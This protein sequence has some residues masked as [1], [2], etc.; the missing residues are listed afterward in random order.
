MIDPNHLSAK[1][2]RVMRLYHATGYCDA[3]RPAQW[4]ALRFFATAPE[5][6]RTVSGLARA[7]ASTMGTTS[8]TVSALV[9]RGLLA[10]AVDHRNVGLTVTQAGLKLLEDADPARTLES[11]LAQLPAGERNLLDRALSDI[12]RALE[13]G[14]DRHALTGPTA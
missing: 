1:L 9:D 4:Q 14:G 8:V 7:R 2:E 6:E 12:I 10:R 13:P 5:A 3:L 11:T